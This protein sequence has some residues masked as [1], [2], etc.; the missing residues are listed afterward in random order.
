MLT[1]LF[2]ALV[3]FLVLYAAP[4]MFFFAAFACL[5]S[6]VYGTFGSDSCVHALEVIIGLSVAVGG[7]VAVGV[8]VACADIFTVG[9]AVGIVVVGIL[10]VAFTVMALISANMAID[11]Y[12]AY[13]GN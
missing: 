8:A 11:E 3:S 12:F 10:P 7:A 5:A 9:I 1:V 2:G 13:K 6:C 4:F